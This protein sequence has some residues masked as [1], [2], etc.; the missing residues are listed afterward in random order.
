[1]LRNRFK[2]EPDTTVNRYPIVHGYQSKPDRK[3]DFVS[4]ASI[5]YDRYRSFCEEKLSQYKQLSGY[6]GSGRD[7]DAV[8]AKEHCSVTSSHASRQCSLSPSGETVEVT[9]SDSS[10]SD[11]SPLPYPAWIKEQENNRLDASDCLD[12]DDD[13][14]SGTSEEQHVPHVLA[15]PTPPSHHHSQTGAQQ[16]P[17]AH[18]PRRC[19]LWACKACKRKTVTV[20]RRKAATLRERKRLRKVNEAFE[21]LKRRTTTNPSQRLPKVE[22]LRNAIDYIES[23]EDILHSDT[24]TFKLVADSKQGLSSSEYLGTGASVQYL[25]ERL[26]TFSDS[27]NRFS[28]A[29]MYENHHIQNSSAGYHIEGATSSLDCLSLIVESI[30]KPPAQPLATDFPAKTLLES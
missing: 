17:G 7:E 29:N 26:Q 10:G 22:I 6:Q 14:T 25:A 2:M 3:F 23:L 5:S 15:P 9:G 19:L 21:V 4:N 13:S 27:I 20:D 30:N 16:V 12:D 28:S 24:G 11:C 1:M 18:G 8:R